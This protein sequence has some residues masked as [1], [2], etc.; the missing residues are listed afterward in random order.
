MSTPIR[1]VCVYCGSSVGS[2][3][4]YAAA[5]AH[6]G[7]ALAR[8]RL[9]LVYGAGNVGLMGIIADAVLRHGGEVIGVIPQVLVDQEVAHQGLGD[10]RIVDTMHERKA[11]MAQLADAFIALPGGM[12]TLEEL[13]EILT[14][15]QLD[16]HA[17]PV[18]LLNLNG[19]YNHLIAYLDHAVTEGFLR[20]G[21][22]ELLRIAQDAEGL[23]D[24]VMA[25]PAGP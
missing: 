10:L 6:L 22:R 19:Y 5:A 20:P 4:G 13:A 17:K 25:D 15:A 23:L 7:E 11:L 24:L 18:V 8:R 2:N 16:L 21:H 1:R 14:W 12:G 9:A 3:E